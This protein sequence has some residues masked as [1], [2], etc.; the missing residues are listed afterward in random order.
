MEDAIIGALS[1]PNLKP[2]WVDDDDYWT[3]MGGYTASGGL[4][5]KP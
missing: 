3:S 1:N 4:I 5:K 2:S